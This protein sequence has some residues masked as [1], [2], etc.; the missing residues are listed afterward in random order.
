M[1]ARKKNTGAATA[2]APAD[3]AAREL[4]TRVRK[5]F[6]VMYEADEENRRD[7][8]E[9][10]KFLHVPGAQWD[11][12][13]RKRRKKRPTYEFNRLRILVKRVLND[14]RANRPQGKVRGVEDNDTDR[15]EIYEGLCRNFWQ[16]SDGDTVLD[17]AGEYQ[18]GGG[19]GAFRIATEYAHEDAFDQDI[20]VLPIRNPFCL[21]WDP[22]AQDPLKRDAQDWILTDRM[23]KDAFKSQYPNAKPVEFPDDTGFDDDDMWADGEFV[24]IAE[25][26]WRE[27]YTKRIGYLSTGETVDMAQLGDVPE[28]AEVPGLPGVVVM[29][30]RDS[31]CHRIKQAIVSGDSILS[32]PN[33]WAGSQ[34]PFVVMFGEHVCIEGRSYWFGMTRFARDAARAY[35][36]TRT[37]I[38]ETIA[39]TPTAKYWATPKQSLGQAQA[40]AEAHESNKPF[41]IYNPDPQA[42]GPPQRT[43]GADVPVALM[44]EAQI[45]SEDM[46]AVVGVFDA[47]LGNRSN[48]SS[49]IAIRARQAQGE[50]ANFN[51]QDNQAKAV[52]RAWEIM[53][54]LIPRIIDTERQ[55]RIIG[56]D[57]A[58]KFVRVN[59]MVETPEGPQVVNDL[60][61]G[62]YDVAVTVG[63][64]FNTRREE[65]AQVF[66]QLGAQAPV[67][68]QAAGDLIVKML[69]VPYG[70]QMAERIKAV[71]RATQPALAQVLEADENGQTLPPEVMAKMQEAEQMMAQVQQQGQLVEQAAAELQGEQAKVEKGK[72]DLELRAAKMEA[73]YQRMVADITKREAAAGVSKDQ[74]TVAQDRQALSIQVAEAV[75]Q[76][77][78][79]NAEFMQQAAAVI[80]EIQ[81]RTQPAVVVP[82]APRIARIESRRVNGTLVAV[83]VYES[84]AVQ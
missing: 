80:A 59:Q 46:K 30:V 8:L 9:D 73:D 14:L 27:P 16:S 11:S 50:I 45:A 12:E 56:A 48:E 53:I 63:P 18:V 13:L 83:P 70:E 39:L 79:Q 55:L 78:A 33:D 57:G 1:A 5:R 17:Y 54:D 62:R 40:W 71:M 2:D 58:E 32:G 15:A 37:A 74:E 6:K 60:K 66:T 34:F 82:P 43:G 76:L 38:A 31:Q 7:A 10:L 75:A 21:F 81:A 35:N 77:A 61:A 42:P 23:G 64:S 84:E 72:A 29:K 4:V 52:R 69:D 47:S 25:Y 24:R 41:A 67:V 44:Q 19:F 3:T 36:V 49:G 22:A 68:W 51:Y 65:A 28:G 20:K 26:W